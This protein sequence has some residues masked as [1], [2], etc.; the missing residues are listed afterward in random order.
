MGI[1]EVKG[2]M[3]VE[4][5]MIHHLGVARGAVQRPARMVMRVMMMGEEI[6]LRLM[7]MLVL[8]RLI[9]VWILR[10]MRWML[11]LLLMMVVLMMQMN[12]VLVVVVMEK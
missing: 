4:W 9:G 11:L 5:V 10:M 12:V 3:G 1:V 7:M 6:R 8:I 2:A